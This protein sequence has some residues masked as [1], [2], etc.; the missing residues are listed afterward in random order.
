MIQR[1]EFLGTSG[2]LVPHTHA[3]FWSPLP[4]PEPYRD[5]YAVSTLGRVLRLDARFEQLPVWREHYRT[6]GDRV[7]G[8]WVEYSH[9]TNPKGKVLKHY[10]SEKGYR[11]VTISAN[12][13]K[14]TILIYRLVARAFHGPKPGDQY[15]VAHCNG[16]PLDDSAANLR[17]KTYAENSQDMI[18]HGHS[19]RGSR[20]P[21]SKLTEQDVIE[22]R[23]RQGMTGCR[24]LGRELDLAHST[25]LRIWTRERWGWL[26]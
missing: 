17:W 7:R 18:D 11:A 6:E 5:L 2:D 3:E 10:V 20:Q 25:I 16:D 13:V 14:K 22:I 1:R 26:E 21:M 8:T 15:V 23:E 4:L 24:A 12:A 9:G 19:L